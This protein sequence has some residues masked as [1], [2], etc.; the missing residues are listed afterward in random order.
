M[1]Y[2]EVHLLENTFILEKFTVSV[3]QK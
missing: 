3:T 2:D 1:L